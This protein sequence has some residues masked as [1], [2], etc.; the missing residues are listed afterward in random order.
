VRELLGVARVAVSVFDLDGGEAEWLA[1]AGRRRTHVGPG[2][3]FP[4]RLMGDPAAL[5]KGEPQIIRTRELPP[6]SEVDALLASGVQAYMVMP[7]I[8]GGRLIGALSFGGERAHF[9]AEQMNIAQE[10]AT[11]LAIAVGQARP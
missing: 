4:I 7:M 10:V 9:P 3:R 6:G 11:Q 1:A 8:A 5:A 2:V